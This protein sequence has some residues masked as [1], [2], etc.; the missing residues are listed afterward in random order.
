MAEN[1]F[2]RAL[3]NNE[4]FSVK[5]I[6]DMARR[7]YSVF[8]KESSEYDVEVYVS[9]QKLPLYILLNTW[10]LIALDIMGPAG[11][12][13]LQLELYERG[14]ADCILTCS[15]DADQLIQWYNKGHRPS[16]IPSLSSRLAKEA[17]HL[18][19]KDALQVLRYPKRYAPKV[20]RKYSKLSES[21]TEKFV[22]IQTEM[23]TVSKNIEQGN[24]SDETAMTL[25]FARR[26]VQEILQDFPGLDG[27]KFPRFGPGS[28]RNCGSSIYEKFEYMVATGA[29]TPVHQIPALILREH[30]DL[31]LKPR[32]HPKGGKRPGNLLRTFHGGLGQYPQV[33]RFSDVP[34]KVNT[35]RGIGPEDAIN[36]SNQLQLKDIVEKRIK[37][38]RF[39]RWMPFDRQETN[40]ELA[41]VGAS[42]NLLSTRDYSSASDTVTKSLVQ[43]LV[44]DDWWRAFMR[45]IP[46]GFIL[47]E[48][49]F[50][51]RRLYSFATMG[52]GCTF[53]VETLIFY[54][55]A[56]GAY[57][58]RLCLDGM[59]SFE[60]V[61]DAEIQVSDGITAMGDDVIVPFWLNP[62]LDRVGE[63]LGFRINHDKTFT[64]GLFRESCGA[65]WLKNPDELSVTSVQSIYYPRIPFEG[66]WDKYALSVFTR[67]KNGDVET[68]T[69][70]GKL[71]ELQHRLFSVSKSASSF[72]RQAIWSYA[73]YLSAGTPDP[74]I[75]DL[76]SDSDDVFSNRQILAYYVGKTR[77]LDKDGKSL[78]S[79]PKKYRIW[80]SVTLPDGY[81][82]SSLIWEFLRNDADEAQRA[83]MH[84][85][86]R[87]SVV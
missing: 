3:A 63:E 69:G 85:E 53:V 71:I 78:P 49:D 16:D 58:Y 27:N 81:V 70:L 87:K 66:D 83:H 17:C 79:V 2:N 41:K 46:T 18:S 30:P 43:M 47:S 62:M 11:P 77:R 48:H 6:E 36:M 9:R 60:D 20:P 26:I 67:W 75:N 54:S 68:V 32:R 73:P 10:A 72:L 74:E 31:E 61:I 64:N 21:T 84:I 7:D 5:F 37:S 34:K 51:P 40:Q 33:A 55:I 52:C 14:T 50:G 76:W 80:G 24:F 65:E 4:Q 38:S 12:W 19:P 35:N 15:N 42:N 45:C 39:G 28:V 13:L 44:P 25:F 8:V 57:N 22:S 1:Y 82:Y 29:Y 59:T 23:K 56:L 86:D